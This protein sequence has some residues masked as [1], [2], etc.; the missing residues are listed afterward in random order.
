MAENDTLLAVGG[1]RL[2]VKGRATRQR[3]V[4][5]A[6]ELMLARG[7]ART[8]IEDIQEA[9][10][11]SASQL[12][13]YFEDKNALV[14]AVIDHE[15]ELVLGIHHQGL[16]ELD[17]FEA[18]QAWRD[19]VIRIVRVADCAGGCPLGGLASDLAEADPVARARLA[20][21]FAQ[22]E[23]MLRVGIAAM[24]ARGELRADVPAADLALSMLAGLE[25][26]L[27]LSQL[28]RDSRPIEVALDTAIAYLRTMRT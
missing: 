14:L 23:E 24:A 3:I 12:Y 7:V 17:S 26:G 27:L 25:G 28:R 10:Q 2:T 5:A 13:H 9:A 1:A 11:V 6:A 19:M 4:S 16:A 21:V 15:S 20:G 22:W 8:T 18:L